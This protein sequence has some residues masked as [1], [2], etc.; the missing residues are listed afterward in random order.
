[1]QL[2]RVAPVSREET[3]CVVVAVDAVTFAGAGQDSTLNHRGS[4][5]TR[6][7]IELVMRLYA[8]GEPPLVV[9]DALLELVQA[10][11]YIDVSLGG[12]VRG[13]RPAR[14]DWQPEGADLANAALECIWTAATVVRNQTLDI[15]A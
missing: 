14:F 2:D 6:A 11:I 12:V 7:D 9:S 13:L 5:A 1:V 15:A 4:G 8:R 3:P 10:R